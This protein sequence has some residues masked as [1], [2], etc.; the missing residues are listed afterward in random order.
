MIKFNKVHVI[1]T[2]TKIKAKVFYSTSARVDGRDCVTLY[3]KTYDR[4]L[5]ALFANEYANASDSMTDYF[6]TGKVRLFSDHP[7]YAAA[8]A[9]A[10]ANQA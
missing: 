8:L 2:D 1:D 4:N 3:A 6:E 10:E 5:G 7:L 9:R